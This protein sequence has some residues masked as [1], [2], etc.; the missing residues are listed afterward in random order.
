[1]AK[2]MNR[3]RRMT[4]TAIKVTDAPVVPPPLT[5]SILN[6][7]FRINRQVSSATVKIRISDYQLLKQLGSGTFGTVWLGRKKKT[8]QFYAIKVRI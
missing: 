3:M 6:T 4:L 7:N 2:V 5:A 1:M 8:S